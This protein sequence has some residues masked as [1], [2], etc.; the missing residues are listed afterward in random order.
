M[1]LNAAQQLAA[2]RA[3]ETLDK[4]GAGLPMETVFDEVERYIARPIAKS[5]RDYLTSL[6]EQEGWIDKQTDTITG[7]IIHYI[8]NTGATVKNRL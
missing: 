5:E 6:M 3:L 1:K 8:T 7:R 4:I 2:K